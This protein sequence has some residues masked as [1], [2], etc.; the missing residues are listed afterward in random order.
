MKKLI[1]TVRIV[2]V[3]RN[4]VVRLLSD[5][6]HEFL[7]GSLKEE[8]IPDVDNAALS[9]DIKNDHKVIYTELSQESQNQKMVYLEL[10]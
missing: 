5:I 10:Y 3:V 4:P 8:K 9:E 6:A 7:T 2:L 1:P